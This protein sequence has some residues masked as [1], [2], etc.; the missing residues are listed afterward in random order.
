MPH[1]VGLEIGETAVDVGK[2]TAEQN[3]IPND[4]GQE[5][6]ALQCTMYPYLTWISLNSKATFKPCKRAKNIDS[7]AMKGR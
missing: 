5:S 7:T 1:Q 6:G 2:S 3:K 4:E